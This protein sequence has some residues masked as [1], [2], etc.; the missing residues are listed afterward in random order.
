MFT[1]ALFAVLFC[2]CLIQTSETATSCDR[3]EKAEVEAKYDRVAWG[4]EVD[5]KDYLK[6]GGSLLADI[7]LH[8]PKYTFKFFKSLLKDQ[9]EALGG[10][11]EVIHLLFEGHELKVSGGTLKGGILTYKCTATTYKCCFR[12]FKPCCCEECGTHTWKLPHSHQAYI[13]FKQH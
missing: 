12:K 7:L 1:Q 5:W 8:R 6:L 9:I 4:D 11:K 10:L 3:S 2:V 13:G